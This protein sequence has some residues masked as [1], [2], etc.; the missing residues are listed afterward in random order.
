M[1]YESFLGNL[2]DHIKNPKKKIGYIGKKLQ[3]LYD[4]PEFTIDERKKIIFCGDKNQL[5]PIFGKSKPALDKRTFEEVGYNVTTAELTTLIRH[6]GNE[7]IQ[8]IANELERNPNKKGLEHLR[9]MNY[10]KTQFEI[11]PK[12]V[13]K[14]EQKFVEYFQKNPLETKYINYTNQFVQSSIC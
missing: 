8:D 14:I 5:P 12:D 7:I 10:D 13:D 4:D 1:L 11:I 3:E 2:L 9:K 6:K